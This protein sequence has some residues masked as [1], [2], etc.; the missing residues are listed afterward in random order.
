MSS[1]QGRR[2][3]WTKSLFSSEHRYRRVPKHDSHPEFSEGGGHGK[4]VWYG[5][6]STI[7][8]K[9]IVWLECEVN[10]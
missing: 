2:N 4:R 7:G 10:K 1:W 5:D 9:Q 3:R 6:W 8:N